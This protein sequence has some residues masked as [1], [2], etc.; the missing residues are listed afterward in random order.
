MAFDRAK[1]EDEYTKMWAADL[2]S[3]SESMEDLF[4]SASNY[5]TYSAGI[6]IAL[7]GTLYSNFPPRFRAIKEY[8]DPD[9][10]LELK[11][12]IQ[13]TADPAQLAEY[14]DA[15]KTFTSRF[16][17]E[18]KNFNNALAD[19]LK[20]I[21]NY[22]NDLEKN[23]RED[24]TSGAFFYGKIEKALQIR[25]RQ[26]EDMACV[27]KDVYI[28]PINALKARIQKYDDKI[29]K[30]LDPQNS[31]DNFMKSLPSAE[32]FTSLTKFS[33]QKPDAQV[34]AMKAAYSV[35]VKGVTYI[36]NI[37]VNVKDMEER[38]RLQDSLNS[39]MNEY[40]KYKSQYEKVI[41][42]YTN[43]KNLV[44]ILNGMK[45]FADSANEMI[46]KL[47]ASIN[48]MEDCVKNK[49]IDRYYSEVLTLQQ[50]FECFWK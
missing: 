29:D 48:V 21:Q 1:L 38:S 40:D 46:E 42:E 22:R 7:T 41:Y 4:A 49:D 43:V 36:G 45:F 27:I 50:Y 28:V 18:G 5:R 47:S 24:L 15:L 13:N 26:I 20:K 31:F 33:E 10:F 39:L 23:F 8:S 2:S 44:I 35:A 14:K 16:V 30:F 12:L 32:E 37:I 19:M 11:N 9:E 25:G 34:E 3:C 17:S 6:Y